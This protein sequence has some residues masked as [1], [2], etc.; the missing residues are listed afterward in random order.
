MAKFS[1]R[2]GHAPVRSVLQIG[3][4]DDGLRNRLWNLIRSTF[5][6]SAPHVRSVHGDDLSIYRPVV[7][8]LFKN[9]W[10]NYFKKATDSIG[11]SYSD[12]L[13]SLRG[14]FFDCEWY[15]VYDLLEFL[16]DSSPGGERQRYDAG[17]DGAR[18]CCRSPLRPPSRESHVDRIDG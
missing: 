8:A 9:L 18:S 14:Y 2:H 5:F 12:A 3:S 6:Y 17:C 1:E 10:H 13:T 7:H 11:N 4:I 16:A 15:E